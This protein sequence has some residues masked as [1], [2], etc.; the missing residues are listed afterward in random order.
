[1]GIWLAVFF[2]EPISLGARTGFGFALGNQSTPELTIRVYGFPGLPASVLREGYAEAAR[3]LRPSR[4]QL[5]WIDC[6]SQV[7]SSACRSPQ[8][9]TDLT[10]RV[11]A[12]ALPE[13]SSGALGMAAWSDDEAGAF[14]F[15][16]RVLA[17]RTHTRLLSSILG[18]VIAHEVTHI[19][20]PDEGHSSYGLMRGRWAPDDLQFASSPV[21]RL[22]AQSVQFMQREALRRVLKASSPLGK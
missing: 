8:L 17:L 5:K 12:R 19:L 22:S 3:V 20:L 15:Y 16:D 21:L 10:V 18:C 9:P 6:M 7:A 13:A 11:I 2:T 14:I 4:I 1:M